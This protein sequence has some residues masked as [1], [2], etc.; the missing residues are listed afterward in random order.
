MNEPIWQS[1]CL[2]Q[3]TARDAAGRFVREA[4]GCERKIVWG[5]EPGEFRFADGYWCYRI[6]FNGGHWQVRRTN[7]LTPK[8]KSRAKARAEIQKEK[9]SGNA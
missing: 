8:A 6:A 9:E 4:F 3:E 1:P 7:T 5:Q 2:P